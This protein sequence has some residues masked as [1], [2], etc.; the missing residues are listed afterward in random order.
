MILITDLDRTT[1]FS[2]KFLKEVE[3]DA[4]ECVEGIQ[5][6]LFAPVKEISFMSKKAV[7]L[8]QELTKKISVVPATARTMKEFKRVKYFRKM[9][10]AITTGGGIILHNGQV[11]KEWDRIVENEIYSQKQAFRNICEVLEKQA[12]ITQKPCVLDGKYIFTKTDN[13]DACYDFLQ[14]ILGNDSWNIFIERRKVYIMPSFITKENAVDFICQ[15]QKEKKRIVAGDTNMDKGMLISA[16]IAYVP[17]HGSILKQIVP[18]DFRNLRIL[19][20]GIFSGETMFKEI[21]K[22]IEKRNF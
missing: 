10:Y 21:L 7:E 19:K 1:I 18:E 16:D 2:K 14:K 9:K 6:H 15:M 13:S 12:F 20:G 11:L 17:S 4:I 3:L 5:K 22:E 8:L